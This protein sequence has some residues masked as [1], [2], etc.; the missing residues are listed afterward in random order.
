MAGRV[1]S[2]TARQ[3]CRSSK[4]VLRKLAAERDLVVTSR[5]KPV[6]ILTSTSEETLAS[7]LSALR[8]APLS[9]IKAE[10]AAAR[11]ERLQ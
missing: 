2:V 8:G 6:A 1:S 10:I 4:T 11:R 3:L 5:G 7:T 9:T